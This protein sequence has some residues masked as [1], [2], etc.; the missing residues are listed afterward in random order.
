M[1]AYFFLLFG[2]YHIFF[3]RQTEQGSKDVALQPSEKDLIAQL[4]VNGAGTAWA[5]FN[6]GTETKTYYR[7]GFTHLL[8]DLEYIDNRHPITVNCVKHKNK[9]GYHIENYK[10]DWTFPIQ[11]DSFLLMNEWQIYA[12]F[13]NDKGLYPARYIDTSS[14]FKGRFLMVAEDDVSKNVD[15]VYMVRCVDGY[16]YYDFPNKNVLMA[17]VSNVSTATEKIIQYPQTVAMTKGKNNY[18]LIVPN[19]N[20]GKCVLYKLNDNRIELM[21]SDV[22]NFRL[23]KMKNLAKAKA[24]NNWSK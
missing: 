1:F 14:V 8:I 16:G 6:V 19:S 9:E 7:D 13:A 21:S 24:K 23:K 17:Y 4:A 10:S 22:Q 18:Y 20:T 15:D 11:D 5:T 12:F 3:V 2:F